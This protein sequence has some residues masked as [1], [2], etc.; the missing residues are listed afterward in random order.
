MLKVEGVDLEFPQMNKEPTMGYADEYVEKTMISGKIRRIYRG[1]R[2][3]AKFSYAFLTDEQ[4]AIVD[5]LLISQRIIGFLNVQ[6]SNP[7]GEYSG[8]AVLE[9][10][11][12]QKRF[13][14][15]PVA[16]D[17]VWTNWSITLKATEYDN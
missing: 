12:D 7:F 13:K 9:L 15:D 16:K 17:Y 5:D 4:K 8:N 11:D 3:Y 2:F 1:R 10:N 14:Y 6:I